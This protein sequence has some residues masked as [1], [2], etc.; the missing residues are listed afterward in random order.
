MAPQ[1][2]GSLS[3][4]IATM[5]MKWLFLG[6]DIVVGRFTKDVFIPLGPHLPAA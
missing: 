5:A 4:F 1:K 2:Y 3:A 6:I